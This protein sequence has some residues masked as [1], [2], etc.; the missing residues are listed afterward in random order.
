MAV[1]PVA[2]GDLTWVMAGTA[3]PRLACQC[4]AV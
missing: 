3:M 4:S 2:S 1:P